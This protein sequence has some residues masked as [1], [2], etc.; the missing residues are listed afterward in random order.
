MHIFGYVT[1][2]FQ[3]LSHSAV[4]NWLVFL[5]GFW[6]FT[7]LTGSVSNRLRH[8][9]ADS[10]L[11]TLRRSTH[12]QTIAVAHIFIHDVILLKSGKNVFMY[13]R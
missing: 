1:D 9:L 11:Q 7:F 8:M 6:L 10:V 3:S 12:V 2:G 13:S 4:L 5:G